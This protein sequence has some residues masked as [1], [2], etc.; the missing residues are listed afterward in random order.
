MIRMSFCAVVVLSLSVSYASAETLNGVIT[1]VKG[2]D[3]I[4]FKVRTGKGKD[5]KLGDAKD[6]KV[7][8][9]VKMA[10]AV[11]KDEVKALTGGLKVEPLTK[12]DA[13]KGVRAM[14]TT[15]ADGVVTEITLRAPR[16]KADAK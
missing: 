11:S 8:K 9:D 13:E 3:T 1:A 4:T 5:A 15:N 7:A 14:I 16:K 6:Y 12:I 2:D 10:Q